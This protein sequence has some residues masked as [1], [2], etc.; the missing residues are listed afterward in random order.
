MR[1]KLTSKNPLAP[2]PSAAVARFRRLDYLYV[3]KK[4]GRIVKRLF[5]A[6]LTTPGRAGELRMT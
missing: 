3:T 5:D 1:A 6:A 2:P 4:N